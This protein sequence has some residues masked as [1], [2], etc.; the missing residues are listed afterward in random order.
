MPEPLSEERITYLQSRG[1]DADIAET[2]LEIVKMK[3]AEP[4]EGLGWSEE[5]LQD[6]EIEYKRYLM[7]CRNIRIAKAMP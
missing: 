6:A 4:K 1:I 5:Q 3:I 7:L 2:D